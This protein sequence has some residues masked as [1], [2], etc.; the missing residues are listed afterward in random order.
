VGNPIA[1]VFVGRSTGWLTTGGKDQRVCGRA[2][3]IIGKL[4]CFKA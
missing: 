1:T 3:R 2:V 4:V